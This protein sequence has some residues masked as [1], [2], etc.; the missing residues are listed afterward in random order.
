MTSL[1]NNEQNI[2]NNMLNVENMLQ[3][4]IYIFLLELNGF[5]IIWNKMTSLCNN[6][7]N[8]HDHLQLSTPLKCVEL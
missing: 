5:K 2:H 3:K 8:I 7:Q 4:F 6:E 1:S